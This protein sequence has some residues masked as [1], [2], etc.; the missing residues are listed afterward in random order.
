[1]LAIKESL[2]IPPYQC[3]YLI[4]LI[5]LGDFQTQNKAYLPMDIVSRALICYR[6]GRDFVVDKALLYSWHAL[7]KAPR[8][9]YV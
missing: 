9:C 4:E 8:R 6:A 7:L 2:Q 3:K 1:M 5:N